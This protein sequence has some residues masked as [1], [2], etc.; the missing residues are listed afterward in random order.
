MLKWMKVQ[1]GS[2][3][4]GY[5]ADQRLVLVVLGVSFYTALLLFIANNSRGPIFV[6][7][8]ALVVALITLHIYCEPDSTTGDNCKGD[9]CA[10]K[11]AN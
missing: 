10:W 7:D 8:I 4:I 5:E 3:R 11:E 2:E 6:L 9:K 1:L